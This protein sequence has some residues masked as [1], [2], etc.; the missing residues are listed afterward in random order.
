[1]LGKGLLLGLGERDG[2]CGE[3]VE[4]PNLGF[5]FAGAVCK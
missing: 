5:L 1:V 3:G 2:D 4:D